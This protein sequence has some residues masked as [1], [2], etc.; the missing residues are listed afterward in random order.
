LIPA[1]HQLD[2]DDVRLA[3]EG[4]E[5]WDNTQDIFDALGPDTDWQ[6]IAGLLDHQ[7]G[8]RKRMETLNRTLGV[9]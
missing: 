5:D 8:L 9:R 3:V 7:P 6:R 1:P 2:R 4:E